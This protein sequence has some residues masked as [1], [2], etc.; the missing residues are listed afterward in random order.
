VQVNVSRDPGQKPDLAVPDVIGSTPTD[1][2][3]TLN[4]SQLRLIYVKL[5]IA[6]PGEIGKI[7]QQSPLGGNKA[8]RNA[9]VLVFLG[10]RG[11]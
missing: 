6:S 11:G 3:T 10:V 4:G 7:V 2:V 5:P 8:P 1:A 9:Q